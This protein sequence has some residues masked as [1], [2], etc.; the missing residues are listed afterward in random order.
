MK[1]ASIILQSELSIPDL[2]HLI[3]SSLDK[4]KITLKNVSIIENDSIKVN[5]KNMSD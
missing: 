1:T 2:M 5:Y 3:E 4:D